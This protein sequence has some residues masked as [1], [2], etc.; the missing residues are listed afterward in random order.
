MQQPD[1][2]EPAP[3]HWVVSVG[4]VLLPLPVVDCELEVQGD[5]VGGRA[6]EVGGVSGI[7]LGGD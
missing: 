7:E 1:V 3:Q 4:P 2:L 5:S 6:A